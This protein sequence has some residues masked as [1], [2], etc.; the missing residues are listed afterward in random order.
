MVAGGGGGLPTQVSSDP[1][2]WLFF[3]T[4][5]AEVSRKSEISSRKMPL[6]LPFPALVPVLWGRQR[7][8][9]PFLSFL[10]GS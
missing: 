2:P 6:L 5:W 3:D 10:V 9:D 8:W 4:L 7:G 1:K